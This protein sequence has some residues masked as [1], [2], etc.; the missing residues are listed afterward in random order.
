MSQ[1]RDLEPRYVWKDH[2]VTNSIF[3]LGLDIHLL[4]GLLVSVIEIPC[5]NNHSIF[6]DK[7]LH[8]TFDRKL[9]N[10]DTMCNSK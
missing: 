5:I 4:G 2:I 9:G 1:K 10:K 8:E 7:E 6:K 3:I